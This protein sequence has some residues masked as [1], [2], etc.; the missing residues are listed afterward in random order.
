MDQINLFLALGGG[1]QNAPAIASHPVGKGP[2]ESA[3]H[4]ETH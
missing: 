1:W 2:G 3:E 4:V